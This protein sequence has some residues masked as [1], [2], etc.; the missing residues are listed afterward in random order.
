M[1]V[2]FRS[3][4]THRDRYQN[5]YAR[6]FGGVVRDRFYLTIYVFNKVE[7]KPKYRELTDVLFEM[8]VDDF[9]EIIKKSLGLQS[10]ESRVATRQDGIQVR[11]AFINAY[12]SFQQ[13]S[14]YLADP[15][16]ISD[17]SF[18]SELKIPSAEDLDAIVGNIT[19]EKTKEKFSE[20]LKKSTKRTKKENR[21]L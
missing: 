1:V 14:L 2:E 15:R 4:N 8:A 10:E 7:T 21:K 3:Q 18:P 12:L 6:I 5:T 16:R 17:P 13:M 19:P 11:E 20:A 9:T